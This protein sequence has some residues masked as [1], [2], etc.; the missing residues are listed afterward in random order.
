M[1]KNYL[2]QKE[3][4]QFSLPQELKDILVGLLLGDLYMQK[5][6][7]FTLSVRLMIHQGLV[8]IDY[9]MHLYELFKIYGAMSPKISN[10]APDK[11]TG[12]IYKTIRFVTYSLPCFAPLFELFYVDGKKVIPNN[13][14]E[15]LT[16][17]GLAYWICDDGSFCNRYRVVLLHT[18]GF[19]L[20][21]VE[22]LVKVLTD[23]FHL[24]C[25]V[26]KSRNAFVIRISPKSLSDLQSLLKDIM[27]SMMLYKIGL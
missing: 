3:R 21:G 23:K 13:I 7:K 22:L 2:T 9:F 11:R 4:L 8:H 5:L 27:P 10:P 16:P 1:K 25:T 24:K 26:N 20:E 19:S 12:K 14:A 15:L 18:Q 6:S 17:L